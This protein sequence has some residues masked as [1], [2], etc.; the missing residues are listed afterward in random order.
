M[1]CFWLDYARTQSYKDCAI[2]CQCV[3]T[4]TQTYEQV[5][6]LYID[7]LYKNSI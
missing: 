3:R 6:T 1:T 2:D 7:N 4:Q 5:I